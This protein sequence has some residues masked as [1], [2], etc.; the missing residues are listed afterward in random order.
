MLLIATPFGFMT[1]LL[2][3][4]VN[5][6]ASNGPRIST[7]GFEHRE[8]HTGTLQV[9]LFAELDGNLWQDDGDITRRGAQALVPFCKRFATVMGAPSSSLETRPLKGQ[10]GWFRTSLACH[11][12]VDGFERRM[13]GEVDFFAAE[14]ADLDDFERRW[15]ERFQ[16]IVKRMGEGLHVGLNDPRN[17]R[18]FANSR[19][20]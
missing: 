2:P 3:F 6:G 9:R 20:A 11:Y 5:R 16:V 4:T 8:K 17:A 14:D 19:A 7:A 1:A 13:V 18:I 15:L 10:E 12:G